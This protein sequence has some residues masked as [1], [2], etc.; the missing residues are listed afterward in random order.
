MNTSLFKSIIPT[1]DEGSG[2][3]MGPKGITGIIITLE[4][5]VNGLSHREGWEIETPQSIMVN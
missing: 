3:L 4:V 5:C 1:N 2:G